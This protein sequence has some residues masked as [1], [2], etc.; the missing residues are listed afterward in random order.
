MKPNPSRSADQQRSPE[1]TP[2]GLPPRSSFR[3]GLPNRCNRPKLRVGRDLRRRPRRLGFAASALSDHQLPRDPLYQPPNSPLG[4]GGGEHAVAVIG[5]RVHKMQKD[6]AVAAH[7]AGNI[8]KHDEWRRSPARAA[9]L[10]LDEPARAQRSAQ[11]RAEISAGAMPV[12][13][14]SSGSTRRANSTDTI[15]E[16]PL[17][18]ASTPAF[19]H[20]S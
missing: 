4:F 12:G 16:K 2:F 6:P 5:D 14:K 18:I 17:Y 11:C 13:R 8:T 10:Q 20:C 9:P 3:T 15:G 1:L 7:R 19:M